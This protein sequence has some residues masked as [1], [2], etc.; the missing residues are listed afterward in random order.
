VCDEKTVECAS[1]CWYGNM[2]TPLREEFV[3]DFVE[4]QTMLLSEK[5]LDETNIRKIE[6]AGATSL[7]S[8][9]IVVA[10]CV[11][12][13]IICEG[14]VDQCF[15]D[16]EKVANGWYRMPQLVPKDWDASLEIL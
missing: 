13:T 6:N 9:H 16:A 4:I 10:R 12:H 14:V 7:T 5:C 11:V 3:T 8:D 1:E 2:N 15:V